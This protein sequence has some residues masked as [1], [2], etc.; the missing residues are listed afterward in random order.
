MTHH[1]ST[2]Q[3]YSFSW[4]SK[5]QLRREGRETSRQ[6]ELEVA[7]LARSSTGGHPKFVYDELREHR[8]ET[9]TEPGQKF[10]IWKVSRVSPHSYCCYAMTCTRQGRGQMS[11]GSHSRKCSITGLWPSMAF[12]PQTWWNPWCKSVCGGVGG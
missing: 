5:W 1:S 6:R 8:L 11:N 12:P 3:E 2:H 7:S 10:R 4:H 9:T